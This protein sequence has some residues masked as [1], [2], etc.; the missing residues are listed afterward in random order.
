MQGIVQRLFR[1]LHPTG[2]Q[3][4]HLGRFWIVDVDSKML[5]S[6]RSTDLS[7]N[8]ECGYL[9]PAF[10]MNHWSTTPCLYSDMLLSVWL[11][12][13]LPSSCEYPQFNTDLDLIPCVATNALSVLAHQLHAPSAI[14]ATHRPPTR[15]FRERIIG[16]TNML[17]WLQ[18]TVV[19]GGRATFSCCKHTILSGKSGACC[20]YQS[21]FTKKVQANKI[22]QPHLHLWFW[23]EV[24][25]HNIK[26]ASMQKL[27]TVGKQK[28]FEIMCNYIFT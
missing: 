8:H 13:S 23:S 27:D 6:A 9:L 25:E 4:T 10:Q 24:E 16:N 14:R 18:Q 17:Q 12:K 20:P 1:H 3:T 19:L 28:N 5:I 15:S 21:D 2:C 7:T 22:S 11:Q 26:L